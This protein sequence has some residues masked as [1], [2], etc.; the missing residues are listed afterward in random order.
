MPEI[1]TITYSNHFEFNGARLAFRKQLLFDITTEPRLINYNNGYWL[2]NRKQLTIL[3]AKK[4]IKHEPITIDCSML[5]W[6]EHCHLD[7]CFN[8]VPHRV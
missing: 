2:V 5:Q 7:E 8:L 6:Y 3:A 4:L 1:Q